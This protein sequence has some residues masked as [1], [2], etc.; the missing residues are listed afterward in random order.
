MHIT[1][2]GVRGGWCQNAKCTGMR[3]APLFISDI[4]VSFLLNMG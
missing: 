4:E 2:V 3:L 1:D